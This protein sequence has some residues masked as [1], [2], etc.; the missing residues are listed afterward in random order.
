MRSLVT[1]T[2][3]L[4]EVES[5]AS[6]CFVSLTCLQNSSAFDEIFVQT[7]PSLHSLP[8]QSM[9]GRPI[10]SILS[11]MLVWKQRR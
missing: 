1:V 2:V 4:S 5:D 3:E 6:K 9:I 8:F 11:Q 10:P 7:T